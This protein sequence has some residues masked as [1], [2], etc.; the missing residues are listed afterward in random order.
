MI[1]T[2]TSP[3]FHPPFGACVNVKTDRTTLQGVVIGHDS[4]DSVPVFEIATLYA[5]AMQKNYGGSHDGTPRELHFNFAE[6]VIDKNGVA[7]E[8]LANGMNEVAKAVFTQATGVVLSKGQGATWREIREWAGISDSAEAL[9][10]ATHKVNVEVKSLEGRV[11]NLAEGRAWIQA[12]LNDG[13]TNLMNSAGKW[14]LSNSAGQGFNL[15]SKGSGM[16]KLRALLG[17]EI[18]LLKAL[19]ANSSH[20][21]GA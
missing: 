15:S 6:A 2:N 16:T 11:N 9:R 7:L 1:G 5:Q 14:V 8:H 19:R 18:E 12:R 21:L 4:K 20:Q 17:A 3:A 10:I 13:Y